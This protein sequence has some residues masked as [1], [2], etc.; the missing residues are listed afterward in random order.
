MSIRSS[1]APFSRVDSC[2][3]G[4]WNWRV[5]TPTVAA[6]AYSADV[7]AL[8]RGPVDAAEAQSLRPRPTNALSFVCSPQLSDV[9]VDI[10]GRIGV[11]PTALTSSSNRTNTEESRP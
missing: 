2:R 6:I 1:A 7:L 4:P 10:N 8:A 11:T 3:L 9:I 5:S